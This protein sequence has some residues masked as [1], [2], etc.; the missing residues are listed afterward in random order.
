MNN[1]TDTVANQ[2]YEVTPP[3]VQAGPR[4]P[5]GAGRRDFYDDPRRKSPVLA[6]VLSLMPGLGQVYIGYYQQGFTNVLVA[7]SII[8][9]LNSELAGG[10][11][12]LLGVFLAFFWLYNVVDAWRRATFYNN[13][14]AGIGPATLPEDFAVTSGRGSLAGGV[15][16]VL[17]GVIALSHTLFG[18]PLDWIEKWWPVAL[19]GVG[20]WLIYPTIAG[21]KKDDAAA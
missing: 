18:M 1:Q 12:P 2:T 17:V 19:I 20:A 3:P 9:V 5:I 21:K 4:P 6:L 8:A 11:E 7:A 16:L 15:A 13:A 14:L 10:A